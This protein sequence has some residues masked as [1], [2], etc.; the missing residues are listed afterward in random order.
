MMHYGMNEHFVPNMTGKRVSFQVQPYEHGV[1]TLTKITPRK[2]TTREFLPGR[3][4][5]EVTYEVF[6]LDVLVEE[7]AHCGAFYCGV[8]VSGFKPT[9]G[10]T[11]RVTGVTY[12]EIVAAVNEDK[13]IIIARCG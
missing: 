11:R 7:G 9:N 13:T 1:G 2:I 10:Q 8:P 6:D 3:G 5:A 4:R 12:G